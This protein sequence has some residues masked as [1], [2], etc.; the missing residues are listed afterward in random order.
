MSSRESPRESTFN[1]G[2]AF[3]MSKYV[4]PEIPLSLFDCSFVSFQSF[5]VTLI[6]LFLTILVF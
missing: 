5:L 4:I 1:W 2:G 3:A 6:N